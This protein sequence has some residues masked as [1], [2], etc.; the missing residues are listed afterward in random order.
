MFIEKEITYKTAQDYADQHDT[1]IWHHNNNRH[2]ALNN[3]YE[4][5]LLSSSK[6]YVIAGSI[7][8]YAPT[9][10]DAKLECQADFMI[11]YG[12]I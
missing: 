1:L 2:T 9:L 4:I 7:T 3:H 10:E 11:T 5:Y 8:W 6:I 12:K